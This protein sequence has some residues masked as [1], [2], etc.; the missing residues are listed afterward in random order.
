MIGPL[1]VLD[2]KDG[3]QEVVPGGGEL[4]DQDHD[5]GWLVRTVE[6]Y[7]PEGAKRAGAVDPGWLDQVLGKG[8]A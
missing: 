4:P 8:C 5:E 1:P 2:R 6:D 7:R 3:E